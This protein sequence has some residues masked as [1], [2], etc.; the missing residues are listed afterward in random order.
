[1]NSLARIALSTR[2]M[3]MVPTTSSRVFAATGTAAAGLSSR[4]WFG[5]GD[6]LKRKVRLKI[7]A[8]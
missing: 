5:L 8:R 1:M 6:D 7:P 4:R 3:S 2:A